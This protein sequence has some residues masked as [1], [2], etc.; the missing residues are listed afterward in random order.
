MYDI[1]YVYR[2]KDE[3]EKWIRKDPIQRFKKKIIDNKV[4]TAS[5]LSNIEKEIELI[6]E[7][8]VQFAKESEY[9]SWEQMENT[10]YEPSK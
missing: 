8:A 3:V 2:T 1:G 10:L 6:L 5:D 4:I 9:P 7:E